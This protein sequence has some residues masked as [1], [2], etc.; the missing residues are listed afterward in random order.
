MIYGKNY[1]EMTKEILTSAKLA[2]QIGDKKKKIIKI[3]FFSIMFFL[4]ICIFLI[5][6]HMIIDAPPAA[7][8]IGSHTDIMFT[9]VCL[10]IASST[11][12]RLSNKPGLGT[13]YRAFCIFIF[14]S[15]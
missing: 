14:D 1:K 5:N 9:A 2:E 15:S 12:A 4:S 7:V 13:D 11:V 10:L 3:S 6:S 8:R